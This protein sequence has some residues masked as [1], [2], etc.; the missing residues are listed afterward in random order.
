MFG[1]PGSRPVFSDTTWCPRSLPVSTFNP[2]PIRP[3]FIVTGMEAPEGR[4]PMVLRTYSLSV[5]GA[6]RP[7]P[8]S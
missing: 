4:L 2:H 3:E 8:L 6:P 1:S 5:R 7:T